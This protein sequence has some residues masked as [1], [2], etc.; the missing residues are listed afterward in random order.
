MNRLGAVA[1]A[2]GSVLFLISL[3]PSPTLMPGG[4][5]TLQPANPGLTA[6]ASFAGWTWTG[7]P[8]KPGSTSVFTAHFLGNATGGA[9]PYNFNWS[10]GDGSPDSTI[11]DPSHVFASGLGWNVT[12]RVTDTSGTKASGSI[13]VRPATFDC[14]AEQFPLGWPPGLI[15]GALATLAVVVLTRRLRGRRRGGTTQK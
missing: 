9:P 2:A 3:T 8:C 10:F 5:R 15:L 6:N 4:A 11:Q 12:L 1:L 7:D 14:P 13:F